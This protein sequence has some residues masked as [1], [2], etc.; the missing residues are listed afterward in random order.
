M[1]AQ[2][3]ASFLRMFIIILGALVLF[4][5]IIVIAANYV[6]GNG[7]QTAANDAMRDKTI[8]ERIKPVGQ[9]ALGAAT[10]AE[11]V[12]AQAREPAKVYQSVCFACHGT[13]AAG[14]PKVGDKAA[15]GPRFDLG[16][17]ALVTT[18]ANGKGAM[19]PRGGNP[20]VTDE[21]LHGTI[22]YMLRESGFDAN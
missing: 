3:D 16:V 17:D 5:I 15:W 12:V 8:A 4:T 13:G 2:N 10:T 11:P 9:V 1:S 18:A 7:E 19:P 14:A 6:G 21:E 22:V 20:T